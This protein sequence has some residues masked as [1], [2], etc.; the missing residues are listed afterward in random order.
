MKKQGL[1]YDNFKNGTNHPEE[2]TEFKKMVTNY[3]NS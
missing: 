2:K 1:S 3:S